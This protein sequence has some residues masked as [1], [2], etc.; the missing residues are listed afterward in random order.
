[1]K[2]RAMQ[3]LYLLVLDPV[4]ETTADPNSYGFR[5]SRSPADALERTHHVLTR[6]NAAQWILDADIR[7]C[8]DAISH[9]WLEANIPMEKMILK[10]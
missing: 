1:M 8:F 5:L 9:T 4:A 6:S 2:D 3:A 10:K 7:S